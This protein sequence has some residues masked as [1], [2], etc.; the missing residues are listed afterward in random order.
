MHTHQSGEVAGGGSGVSLGGGLLVLLQ[1]SRC[2]SHIA[3]GAPKHVVGEHALV[4]IPMAVEVAGHLQHRTVR[5]EFDVGLVHRLASQQ[6]QK[7]AVRLAHRHAVHP[8]Q[9]GKRTV[10]FDVHQAVYGSQLPGHPH[11]SAAR[12]GK[13]NRHDGEDE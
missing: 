11:P 12:G 5:S 3:V 13:K 2:A 4:G 1:G 7:H 9:Q 6:L 10:G 8:A